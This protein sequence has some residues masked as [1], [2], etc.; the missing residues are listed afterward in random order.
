MLDWRQ[1]TAVYRQKYQSHSLV[2]QVLG[3]ESGMMRR[4][5]V[6][7]EHYIFERIAYIGQQISEKV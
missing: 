7:D 3:H 6:C 5:V 2:A 1:D 4:M